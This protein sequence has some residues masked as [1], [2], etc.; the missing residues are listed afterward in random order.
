MLAEALS[1]CYYAKQ[2]L[3]RYCADILL[4]EIWMYYSVFQIQR[5]EQ[6]GDGWWE[7]AAVEKCDH[8][9]NMQ[10]P[11]FPHPKLHLPAQLAQGN[12]KYLSFWISERLKQIISTCS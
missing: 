1:I 3:K 7:E 12:F 8:F 6:E 10:I 5:P 4:A 2:L 11:R 9:H